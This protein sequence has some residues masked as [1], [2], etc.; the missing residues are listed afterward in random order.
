MSGLYLIDKKLA[1][2]EVPYTTYFRDGGQDG[3][4]R[5]SLDSICHRFPTH[6]AR[7]SSS[8]LWPSTPAN[9][10]VP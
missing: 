8:R 5:Q 4:S 6:D 9:V 1:L 3:Q 10:T 7:G 2:N